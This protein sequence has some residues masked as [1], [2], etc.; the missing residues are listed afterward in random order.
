MLEKD[1]PDPR[2]IPRDEE[3]PPGDPDDGPA[4]GRGIPLEIIRSSGLYRSSYSSSFVCDLLKHYYWLQDA[5]DRSESYNIIKNARQ[6]H[7]CNTEL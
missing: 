5:H 2:P 1:S 6:L 3:D 7:E 4:F